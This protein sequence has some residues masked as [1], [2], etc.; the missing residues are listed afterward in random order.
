VIRA[1]AAAFVVICLCAAPAALGS[2]RLVGTAGVHV[3]VPAHWRAI[4]QSAAPPASG[5]VDPVTR[6]VTASGRIAFGRGCNQL[7]YV[8]A[9]TAVAVIVVEWVRPTPG[10]KWSPRPRKF[11]E[12]NLPVR[13]GLLECFA[14]RGGGIQ[15]ADK[16]RRFAAYVLAAPRA[17][18]AS[19]KRARA[20]LD[21]LTVERR[22]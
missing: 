19:V 10:T 18:A 13:R 4:P 2:G 11:T 6:I 3:S 5:V 1:L 21:A 15:F 9:P 12:T 20:V 17:S 16:G 8:L 7:D 22:R 14:G